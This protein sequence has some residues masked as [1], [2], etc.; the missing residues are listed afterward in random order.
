MPT[1]ACDRIT[2]LLKRVER[3]DLKPEAENIRLMSDL[4]KTVY[5]HQR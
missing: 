1:P 3:G 5:L 4:L 2:D